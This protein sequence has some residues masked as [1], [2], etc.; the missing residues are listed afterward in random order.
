M[1]LSAAGNC[2]S[3]WRSTTPQRWYP[4]QSHVLP[5][6]NVLVQNSDMPYRHWQIRPAHRHILPAVFLQWHDAASKRVRSVPHDRLRHQ[7]PG[8]CSARS[9]PAYSPEVPCNAPSW[10]VPWS[11]HLR[12]VPSKSIHGRLRWSN[13]LTWHPAYAWWQ[14]HPVPY[15]SSERSALYGWSYRINVSYSRSW[16]PFPN[17]YAVSFWPFHDKRGWSVNWHRRYPRLLHSPIPWHQNYPGM[18]P[19]DNS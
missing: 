17:R 8:W 16:W 14:R 11:H 13:I 7:I 3:A 2:R 1:P 4:G 6:D 19:R 12:R 10:S 18:P 5:A 15:T 9:Y